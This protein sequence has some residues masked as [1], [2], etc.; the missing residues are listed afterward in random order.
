M[1]N[2][3]IIREQLKGQLRNYV[4][5]ITEKSKG[6]NKYVCPLCSSGTGKNGTGAFTITDT[7]DNWKCFAC[8]EGGDI[9]DLVGNVRGLTGYKEQL[10]YLKGLYS[11]SLEANNNYVPPVP[12]V[13]KEKQEE[14]QKTDY[15][16][17]FLEAN[18][19]IEKTDYHRGISLDTLN[20]F[21]IGYI[22]NWKAKPSEMYSSPRLII[23]TSKYS[24][25]ARDTRHNLTDKQK[26]YS[27]RKQG[28]SPL[29]NPEALSNKDKPIYIVE[30]EID[31]LSIID[32]GGEAV[33]LGSTS[34]TNSLI[35]KIK[36]LKEENKQIYQPLII[37]MDN[38]KAGQDAS[39]ELQ[40]ALSSLEV[41]HYAYDVCNGYKDANEALNKDRE[42]F[43]SRVSNAMQHIYAEKY[44]ASSYLQE[45]INGVVDS[46]NTPVI[47]TGFKNLDKVLDGGLYEGLYIVGA[48][49]SLGKTTLIT[50]IADQVAQ[51]GNDV[52]IFSLEMARSEIMAKSISRL[53]KLLLSRDGGN[54]NHAK[55]VRGI[56]D[57]AR[58]KDYCTEEKDLI[59]EAI[60]EYSKYA[61]HIY[62]YEG[63]GDIG[64]EKVKNIIEN[65]ISITGNTP[66]IVIDYLQ[67]LA[68][69]NDRA[70][71]KQNIDKAVI[72]LKR[73]SRDFKLPLIAISSFN[74]DSYDKTVSMKSF[75]E[76]GG[77]EYSC[78]VL[79][80][81]QFEGVAG[82][83]EKEIQAKRK[84]NRDIELVI[85]KN[86]NGQT[87]SKVK[88]SYIPKYNLFSEAENADEYEI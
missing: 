42:A 65:H 19:N 45:F 71:D 85:L 1:Y 57:G 49:S 74:R 55:T 56:T 3:T 70:S 47:P 35:N 32:A 50:Q 18:K 83:N 7:G 12:P 67:I 11:Y 46:V 81:L 23:P 4:E 60:N 13:R 41:E 20:K 64:T 78:D 51:G 36:K 34:N 9:F 53:T 66:L 72:E 33:G 79:M 8:N 22:E 14:E 25:L 48:I 69:Y 63:I 6:K 37:S 62:I 73:I 76:S 31:A 16:N 15:T 40:E 82:D 87:G 26:E 17:F 43:K 29:F 38:D 52:I 44:S 80:G 75:K 24:Y 86:R 10:D 58:Y 2:E 54:R 61:N 59:T 5:S 77:V 39:N 30:G 28:G 84:S 68:P 21:K 88:Y 27:K